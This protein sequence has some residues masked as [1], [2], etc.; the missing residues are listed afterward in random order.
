VGRASLRAL[1]Q[2]PSRRLVAI[3]LKFHFGSHRT[4]LNRAGISDSVLLFFA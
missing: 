1:L 2:N 3:S 4:I